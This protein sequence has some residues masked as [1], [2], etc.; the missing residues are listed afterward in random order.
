MITFACKGF[1]HDDIHTELCIVGAGAAG[2]EMARFFD[3]AELSVVVIEGGGLEFDAGAQRLHRIISVGKDIGTSER[4]M[5]DLPPAYRH[6]TRIRQF[7]GT[8]NAWSESGS[9]TPRTTFQSKNWMPHSGWPLTYQDLL[10]FYL[11]VARD[12]GIPQLLF[13]RNGLRRG[14]LREQAEDFHHD[15]IPP[16]NFDTE[17]R[18]ALER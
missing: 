14:G 9:R 1:K 3:G 7:G 18:T 6:E 8:T 10:P 15:Q 5:P 13:D 12:Y 2:L 4:L 11:P 17:L 16:L